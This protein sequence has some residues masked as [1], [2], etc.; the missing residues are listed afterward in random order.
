MTVKELMAKLSTMNPS[1]VLRCPHSMWNEEQSWTEFD[2]VYDV[3][4]C[5][6]FVDILS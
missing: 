5:G 6:D 3:E 4:Q 2:D 1:S